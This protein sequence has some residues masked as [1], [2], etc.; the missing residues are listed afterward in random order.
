MVAFQALVAGFA[1]FSAIASL[2][3][4]SLT[5]QLASQCLIELSSSNCFLDVETSL[6]LG[7]ILPLFGY[8]LQWIDFWKF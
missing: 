5:P 3:A 4:P 7:F 2:V 6:I 1:G 8:Y